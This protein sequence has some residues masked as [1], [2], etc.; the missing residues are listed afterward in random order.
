MKT[1]YIESIHDAI[2]IVPFLYF[3]NNVGV[4][5]YRGG[6]RV[7]V[8]VVLQVYSFPM[9]WIVDLCIFETCERGI[10]LLQVVLQD[11]RFHP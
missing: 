9:L 6:V 8:A 7:R 1:I 2:R 10:F 4:V 3:E 11:N 5:D